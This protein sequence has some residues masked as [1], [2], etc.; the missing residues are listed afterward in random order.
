MN[1]LKGMLSPLEY[2]FSN[3]LQFLYGDKKGYILLKISNLFHKTI[4]KSDNKLGTVVEVLPYKKPLNVNEYR[5]NLYDLIEKNEQ[6]EFDNYI[7][8]LNLDDNDI[9]RHAPAPWPQVSSWPTT[10]RLSS[11]TTS[12]RPSEQRIPPILSN[13]RSAP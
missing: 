1:N 10:P 9:D 6:K 12:L 5:F 7:D 4:K 13:T 11:N 3:L 2:K 8:N